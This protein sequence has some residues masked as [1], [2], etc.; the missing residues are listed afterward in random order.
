MGVAQHHQLRARHLG[1][2][3]QGRIELVFKV[4][5][6]FIAFHQRRDHH[7][8][9]VLDREVVRVRVARGDPHRRHGLVQRLGHA[10]RGGELP[11]L[12]VV[13]VV[14]LPQG[15]DHRDHLTQG[16]TALGGGH[17]PSHAVELEL[18]GAAGQADFHAAVADHIE[19]GAFTGHP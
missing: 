3:G 8:A 5:D 16:L 12:A 1:V 10:G 17:A 6:F 2:V 9:A 14:A 15:T 19:Q 18:V 7:V 4:E 11:D 13:G